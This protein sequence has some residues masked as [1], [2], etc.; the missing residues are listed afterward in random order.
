MKLIK[1]IFNNIDFHLN[2]QTK[3]LIIKYAENQISLKLDEAGKIHFDA[4]LIIDGPRQQAI[5]EKG[6]FILPSQLFCNVAK[7]LDTNNDS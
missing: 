4:V 1:N 2:A 7:S 6:F 5:D 3:S